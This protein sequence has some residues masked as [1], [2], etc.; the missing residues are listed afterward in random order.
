M[1]RVTADTLSYASPMRVG[2]VYGM[3]STG[4]GRRGCDDVEG[5]EK[6]SKERDAVLRVFGR[7]RR[8]R[9]GERGAPLA[10]RARSFECGP[11]AVYAHVAAVPISTIQREKHPPNRAFWLDRHFPLALDIIIIAAARSSTSCSWQHDQT[12]PTHPRFLPLHTSGLFRAS[13]PLDLRT[14]DHGQYRSPSCTSRTKH[15]HRKDMY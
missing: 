10:A 2:L 5:D 7:A 11:L 15:A 12:H 3:S 4:K 9:E 13:P 1:G 14:A 8:G 6:Q